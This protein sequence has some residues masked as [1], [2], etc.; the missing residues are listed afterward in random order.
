MSQA[1]KLPQLNQVT[2]CGRLVA[3]PHKLTAAG[4][5]EGTAFTL[6]LNRQGGKDKKAI[7]TYVDVTAWGDVAVACNKF[8]GTGSAVM[9]S[10]AL[11][12]F[13]KKREKGSAIKVLQ[14]SASAIQFLSSP[15]EKSDPPTA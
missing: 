10:G 7:V 12:N 2:L 6:A 11:A 15:P 8:L 5:R 9:V 4:D 3:E 14:V 13:E 1:L